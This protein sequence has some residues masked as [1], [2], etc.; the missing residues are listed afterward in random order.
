M[1]RCI[2][3]IAIV[4][5]LLPVWLAA[6]SSAPP[7]QDPPVFR[8][9]VEAVRLDAFVTDTKGN[10]VA[11]LT[12]DD[13][14]IFEDG[15]WQQVQLFAPVELPLPVAGRRD[16]VMPRDIAINDEHQERIYVIVFDSLSW[17]SAVRA[18]K[19]VQRFL[20][21]Y[22]GDADVAALVTLDQSGSMHFTNDRARLM[23]QA[24]AFVNRFADYPTPVIPGQPPARSAF[25]R[26]AFPTRGGLERANA[27]GEIAEALGH[28]EARRK[29]I[30][31]IGRGPGFDPYDAIDMPTSSFTEEARA[32][33]EPIMAANLTVYPIYPGVAGPMETGGMRALA[34]VTGAT[35]IGS[36]LDRAFRQIVRDNSIYYVL[37]YDSTNR[38]RD[39]GYRRI[40]VRM[41]RKDL[42][43]RARDGYFVEFPPDTNPYR[44]VDWS[45]RMPRPRRVSRP[46]D[47]PPELARAIA[48]PVALTAVPMRVFASPHRTAADAG[49]VSVVIELPPSGP[50]LT[51][52]NGRLTGTIDVA[53]GATT[54]GSTLLRS[55]QFTYDVRMEG[56]ERERALRHGLRLTADVTLNPGD[57]RLH[58]AAAP[59]G[60]RVG[61]VLY[62]LTVPDFNERLLMMS[63]LSL[64]SSAA[65]DVPTL[66][67]KS[68]RATLSTPA[69]TTREFQR[70]DTVSVY[71]EVYENVWWTD[72]DHTITLTTELEDASGRVIPMT[73][74]QRP[75]KN[76]QRP[77]G[78]G[79]VAELPL[80]NV[81]AGS[82]MLRVEARSTYGTSRSAVREVPIAV[83]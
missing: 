20:D 34:R 16:P 78:E 50:G 12:A 44:L 65:A 77:T 57:Y 48:S 15:R 14:E 75:P 36:D 54:T 67:A 83:K 62:D 37:G 49:V 3:F 74:E 43:V 7:S 30:L 4:A 52:S 32:A 71:V 24:N 2:A 39:G 8:S 72:S 55:T 27:F 38:L 80:A 22:F 26:I 41:K 11:G 61:K 5:A 81:P 82:Y 13:F 33:M 28:L 60:G 70:S 25:G 47:L 31:Y 76:A 66:Q 40:K 35:P 79:F 9:G 56:E 58:V 68:A 46:S 73:S 42:N 63:G 23:A 59:R 21:N 29:S 64:T 45:G 1:G 6:Q 53:V 18:T 51:D 19:I 69:T 17:A 10:A